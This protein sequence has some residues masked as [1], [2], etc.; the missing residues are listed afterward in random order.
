VTK[1]IEGDKKARDD[2]GEDVKDYAVDSR[3]IKKLFG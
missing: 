1:I 2:K 3:K